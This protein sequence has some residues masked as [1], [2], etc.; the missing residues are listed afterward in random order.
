[1]FDED[2]AAKCY[3]GITIAVL[4]I[5]IGTLLYLGITTLF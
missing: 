1:M 2:F 3:C 5:L 4:V